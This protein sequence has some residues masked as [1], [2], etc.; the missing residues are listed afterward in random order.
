MYVDWREKFCLT[1]VLYTFILVSFAFL[2]NIPVSIFTPNSV[3][4]KKLWRKCTIYRNSPCKS[5]DPL[6]FVAYRP[7]YFWGNAKQAEAR[8]PMYL[9]ICGVVSYYASFLVVWSWPS[10]LLYPCTPSSPTSHWGQSELLCLSHGVSMTS[11]AVAR[12]DIE[13]RASQT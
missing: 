3:F 11:E 8:K 6:Y 5:S 9:E 2:P 13:D 12:G 4:F 1:S 10:G 7:A